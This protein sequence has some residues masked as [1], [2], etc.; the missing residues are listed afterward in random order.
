MTGKLK[1]CLVKWSPW[2]DIVCWQ[3]LFWVLNPQAAGSS[4]N[5]KTDRMPRYC[6]SPRFHVWSQGCLQSPVWWSSCY[7]TI[8]RLD[9]PKKSLVCQQKLTEWGQSVFWDTKMV[10]KF[11]TKDGLSKWLKVIILFDK[12]FFLT[13]L[14]NGKKK[15]KKSVTTSRCYCCGGNTHDTKFIF[16]TRTRVATTV[17]NR[18]ISSEFIIPNS[19]ASLSKQP[20]PQRCMLLRLRLMLMLMRMKTS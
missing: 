3:P 5:L 18:A 16:F 1:I 9:T 4:S 13:L 15:K 8:Y 11:D 2:Q 20:K 7:T 17:E 19:K 10:L 14:R 12:N 6:L